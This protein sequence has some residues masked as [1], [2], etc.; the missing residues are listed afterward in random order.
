[1]VLRERMRFQCL[2]DQPVL[3]VSEDVA[4]GQVHCPLAA[5]SDELRQRIARRKCCQDE[6]ALREIRTHGFVY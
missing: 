1:M 5:V 6:P 2:E 4:E 3:P